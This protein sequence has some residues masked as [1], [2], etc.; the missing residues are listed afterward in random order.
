MSEERFL[1]TC[2]RAISPLH[3]RIFG[4]FG[5]AIVLSLFAGAFVTHLFD[6]GSGEWRR[7]FDGTRRLAADR[8]AEVWDDE[9]ARTTL[10]KQ[11]ANELDV[12]VTLR[13]EHGL[14]LETIG[15]E[16]DRHDA[17][18]TPKVEGHKIG[19]VDI[20][21]KNR[22]QRG[23]S[24]LL[25]LFAAGLVLWILALRV[26]RWLGRPIS[27]LVSAT[28]AIGRGD[29]DVN[30]PCTRHDPP[31]IQRLSRAVVDM[32]KRIKKQLSDQRELLATVSHEVRS[33]LA[34]VRLLNELLRDE[35]DGAHREKLLDD[36]E[37]EIVEID[38]LV[39]GLLAQSRL[40]FT[41]MTL[42]D[43]DVVAITERTIERAGAALSP[44]V[45]GQERAVACDATLFARALSNLVENARKHAGGAT[46]VA[47]VFGRREVSL[48][49][50][51]RGPGIPAEHRDQVFEAFFSA[52]AGSAESLGLGLALVRRIARAHGGD[53]FTR[54]NPGG[55]TVVGF[56]IPA[57]PE[58]KRRAPPR[59][60]IAAEE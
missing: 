13:D 21:T 43:A 48:E 29:Y 57:P 6:S 55:G 46:D 4:W 15:P 54:D 39:G 32:A 2:A 23:L 26:S 24:L 38:D 50:A 9:E 52:E 22:P 11:V 25:G 14:L 17:F 20:C 49:V 40:D 59:E 16:C 8:F 37:Q 27:A 36:L 5:V 30:L 58:S 31:E 19:Q 33:P 1:V 3:R 12:D 60:A 47:V 18:L 56:S 53:A 42:R 10:A 44:R 34:R 45:V 28:D 41:A 7:M 51:D 35:P